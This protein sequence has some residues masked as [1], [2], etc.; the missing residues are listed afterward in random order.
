MQRPI[1]I[2]LL[3]LFFYSCSPVSRK[4]LTKTFRSAE[5]TFRDHTGFALY[6]PEKNETV[7]EYN[8]SKYFT[9]ASNTK[10]FTF[11]AGLKLLG[12]SIPAIKYI[13]KGDSL[14]FC[15]TGD[16]SFLYKNVYDN[17]RIYSFLKEAAPSLFFS[18]Y[19][20]YAERFGPGWSWNDYN[21]SYSSERSALPVYGN[22]STFSLVSNQLVISPPFF[23]NFVSTKVGA[24]RTDVIRLEDSNQIDFYPGLE[25]RDNEWEIPFRVTP[26]LISNLL[27]DTLGRKV[28][29]V[30]DMVLSNNFFYGIPSD[31]LYKVM[32]QESD[33]FIAEQILLMCSGIL[34]DSLKS[35]I[36]IDYMKKNF[37]Q[38]L[39]DE[40]VWVDGSGLSRYNLFTPRSI[41]QLW[42]RIYEI[43]PQERLFSL[44]ATGGVAGTIK[45]SY[46]GESKPYIFG[47]TG[48]LRNNHCLSGFLITKKNKVL[49]F[50]FMNNNYTTPTRLIR[51]N[52]ERTLKNIYENY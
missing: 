1:I 45:N 26:Q 46:H 17:R 21:S 30:D 34:S 23:K 44:L 8:S 22:I 20:F 13:H 49:I 18:T 42:K 40:P 6:D 28:G 4:A 50:S 5:N 16:P 52:M 31:S 11:Y 41:I 12:D 27:S 24:E 48:T 38:D 32:M 2:L 3:A 47:K 9:P 37:L 43:V 36:A 29:V 33:N 10:I 35:E 15:G 51:E 14:I 25:T 39:P 19:N 7:F